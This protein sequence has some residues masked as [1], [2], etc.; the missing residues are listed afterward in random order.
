MA[1][2][3]PRIQKKL[4]DKPESQKRQQEEEVKRK[5]PSPAFDI[6]IEQILGKKAKTPINEAKESDSSTPAMSYSERRNKNS[7]NATSIKK[8]KTEN[9]KDASEDKKNKRKTFN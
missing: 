7:R 4:P 9:F 3:K 8:N 5:T 1:E 2:R 6:P